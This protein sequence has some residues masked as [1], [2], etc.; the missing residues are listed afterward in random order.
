MSISKEQYLNLKMFLGD[1][2]GC[3]IK[4]AELYAVHVAQLLVADSE[5]RNVQLQEQVSLWARGSAMPEPFKLDVLEVLELMGYTIN[6]SNYQSLISPRPTREQFER[7]M[8]RKAQTMALTEAKSPNDAGHKV[9][10]IVCAVKTCANATMA[11]RLA[12]DAAF[13]NAVMDC[14]RGATPNYQFN[15]EEI[16][17]LETVREYIADHK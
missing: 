5:K 12:H 11:S 4:P 16:T 1:C 13:A 3:G 9:H 15:Y 17:F 8:V 6:R 2:E 7:E 14:L 10:E